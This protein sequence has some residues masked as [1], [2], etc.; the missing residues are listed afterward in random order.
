MSW[1]GVQKHWLKNWGGSGRKPTPAPAD[2]EVDKDARYTGEVAAYYKHSGYGFIVPDQEGLVPGDKI[3]VYWKNIQSDDRFPTL[4]QG[5]KVE[6]GLMKKK[7]EGVMTL[8][9]KYVT[10]PG[11]SMVAIQDTEDSKKT[12][13]GGQNLRYTGVLKF[14]DP[15][16]GFGYVILDDGFALDEPVP[17]DLRVETSE[18]NAGGKQPRAMKDLSVEF[19]IWKTEKGA[20]KVYNMTLPGG[21]PTT[22]EALE[23]RKVLEDKTYT[24]KVVTWSWHGGWGWILPDASEV[25]PADVQSKIDVMEAATT[26]KG[27]KVEF[28]RAVY[29]RK[30]DCVGDA[31]QKVDKE[32]KVTFQLYTDDKGVGGTTVQLVVTDMVVTA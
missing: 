20:Y 22:L 10:L 30:Q 8:C 21:I 19:G 14:Y 28:V 7:D 4:S 23:H 3:F 13:V 5:M 1:G 29:F 27:K 16:R 6:F 25:F 17:K 18:V 12:F 32:A 11:G 9:T 2:F 24:G 15:E 26:A 31:G